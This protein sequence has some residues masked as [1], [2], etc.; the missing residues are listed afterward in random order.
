MKCQCE[1]C[2]ARAVGWHYCEACEA[3]FCKD[4]LDDHDCHEYQRAQAKAEK[5]QLDMVGLAEKLFLGDKR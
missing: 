1:N 3:W 4:C 2:R 5:A